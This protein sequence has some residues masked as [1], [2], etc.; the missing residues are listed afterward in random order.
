MWAHRQG[1]QLAVPMAMQPLQ[2]LFIAIW[3]FLAKSYT[4]RRL[5]YRT[6]NGP[7]KRTKTTLKSA[8]ICINHG[9][10]VGLAM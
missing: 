7:I 10:R 1:G 2:K 6:A 4:Y 9:M 3:N 5:D 8:I